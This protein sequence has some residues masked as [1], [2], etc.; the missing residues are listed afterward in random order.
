MTC[1]PLR[2]RKA[3]KLSGFICISPIYRLKVC[4]KYIFMEWHSYLG[5]TFYTD[6]A[7]EKEYI[8]QGE[9]DVIWT[10]FNQWAEK[11]KELK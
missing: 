11:H 6:R 7:F 10:V 4:G 9:D 3:D 2:R 8:P 5:P 1:I